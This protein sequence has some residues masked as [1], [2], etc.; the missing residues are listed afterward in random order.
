[1]KIAIHQPQY[2]PWLGFF[3]KMDSADIFVL[4][5]D[6]QY[7]KNE[8]QN[9][10]QLRNAEG[11]Q[12]I[13]VPVHVDFGQKISEVK[14][15]NS[16][17]WKEKHLKSL[18]MNYS[19]AA[20]FTDYFPLFEKE[21]AKDW[22]YLVNLNITFIEEFK[23]A[24]GIGTEIVK[25]SS[26]NVETKSTERL[27][28]ICKALNA[29]TYIAGPGCRDYMDTGLFDANDI[30]LEIQEYTHPEYKQVFDGF[31]PFMSVVD[32]LFCHGKDSLEIIRKGGKK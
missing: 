15:D 29:D 26:L 28:D 5:D 20:F 1:M 30:G 16:K 7:K 23:K 10:N 14:I 18:E 3:Y 27:I 25:S 6:V 19:H 12:W 17:P 4:L 8:W 22:E 21:F 31:E 13:T 11:A 32:L 24:L 2:M 9:R